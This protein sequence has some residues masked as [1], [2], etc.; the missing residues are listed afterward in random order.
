MIGARIR[1]AAIAPVPAVGSLGV[2][3]AT[4]PTAPIRY[5]ISP[6]DFAA[7]LLV[8]LELLGLSDVVHGASLNYPRGRNVTVTTKNYLAGRPAEVHARHWTAAVRQSVT[9]SRPPS[10]KTVPKSGR[11]SR[12]WFE[13]LIVGSAPE[14][15]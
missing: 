9:R 2:R 3:A 11:F 7:D 1:W 6:H 4:V 5:P 15:G 13:Y 14:L 10:M 12:Q 8:V